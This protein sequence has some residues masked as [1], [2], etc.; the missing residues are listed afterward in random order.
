MKKLLLA[1]LG[2]AIAAAASG[3][4]S[5]C[6]TE[7]VAH[8]L[9]PRANAKIAA[10]IDA[11]ITKKQCV[12]LCLDAFALP[13][14]ATVHAC[15]IYNLD[16]KFAHVHVRY[17]EPDVCASTDDFYWDDGGD[18]GSYDDGGYDDGYYDDSADD[19]GGYDDGGSDCS[20]CSTDDGGSYDDGGYDDGGDGGY[21]DGGDTGDD[22]GYD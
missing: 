14:D 9:A 5:T 13:A 1:S 21:D 17:S 3:C 11:C 4:T 22:G 19:G 16:D 12:P 20:D 6:E 10:E 18:D 15:T 2:L 7:T 8:T